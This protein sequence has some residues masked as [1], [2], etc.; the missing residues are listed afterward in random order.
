MS[1][2]SEDLRHILRMAGLRESEVN[3]KLAKLLVARLNRI[4]IQAREGHQTYFTI[5]NS[6][7]T[8]AYRGID[9]VLGQLEGRGTTA[10]LENLPIIA[11]A[12]LHGNMITF[13]ADNVQCTATCHEG[14]EGNLPYVGVTLAAR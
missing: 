13:T 7:I 2:D 4:G 1:S 12:Q 6:D 10:T 8:D 14:R 5:H 3:T 11:N 9:K